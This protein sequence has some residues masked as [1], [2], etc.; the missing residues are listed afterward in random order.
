[1]SPMTKGRGE[2]TPNGRGIRTQARQK[3]GVIALERN[4]AFVQAFADALRDILR[5]ER[6]QVA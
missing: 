2:R 4:E 6:R 3:R 1:M 5:E